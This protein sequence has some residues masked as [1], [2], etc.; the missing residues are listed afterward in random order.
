MLRFTTLLGSAASPC[1]LVTIGLF[2]A[3]SE[4][5]AGHL[6]SIRLVTLKLLV[7]PAITALFALWVFAMPPIWAKAAILLG[8]L[9]TGTGPFMLA[10]LYDREAAVTSRVILLSTALSIV[11]VSALVAWL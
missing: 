2:L 5:P 4:R 10:K 11:T 7:Q 8:A 9:P 1:A 3:H 6:A